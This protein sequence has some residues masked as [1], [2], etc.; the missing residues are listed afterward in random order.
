MNDNTPSRE[1]KEIALEARETEGARLFSPSA[2]R[3]KQ[4]IAEAFAALMPPQGRILEIGAGTGEHGVT[5]S[6][7]LPDLEWQPSDPDPTSR[8]SIAAWAEAEGGG[9]VM[10][11]LMIDVTA[12]AWWHEVPAALA[13]LSGL[14]SINMIH[15]APFTA[16]E[17]LFAG[18][19]ALLGEDGGLFLYG[20]FKRQGETAESNHRFDASLKGRDPSWGVRDLD[21]GIVPLA[22][23][24][25]LSLEAVREMPANNLSVV[26]KRTSAGPFAATS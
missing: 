25:G 8:A 12:P 14:V 24:N 2:A 15:I 21:I 20:P 16:A 23:R 1:A 5:I 19:R 17:G 9:R 6:K 22:E 26:F 11:P 3:N 7:A 10:P 13:P 4:A 18:A